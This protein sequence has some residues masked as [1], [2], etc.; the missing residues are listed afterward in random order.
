MRELDR[1]GVVGDAFD[2]FGDGFLHQ[3]EVFGGEDGAAALRFGRHGIFSFVMGQA[4]WTNWTASVDSAS[5]VVELS[6]PAT[7]CAIRSK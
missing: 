2:V 5:A 7:V 1:A 3:R 4:A 6:P